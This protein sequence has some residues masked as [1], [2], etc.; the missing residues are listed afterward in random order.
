MSTATMSSQRALAVGESTSNGKLLPPVPRISLKKRTTA[1]VS[2]KSAVCL[3]SLCPTAAT[4]SPP[5]A[6]RRS[7]TPEIFI[8]I[9]L[10]AKRPAP[11]RMPD[12]TTPPTRRKPMTDVLR[13]PFIDRHHTIAPRKTIARENDENDGGALNGNAN[14]NANSNANFI[15]YS[16]TKKQRRQTVAPE[17]LC[18]STSS[19]SPSSPPRSRTTPNNP[20]CVLQSLK[21][22]DNNT[23]PSDRSPPLAVLEDSER[24]CASN[25]TTPNV[26]A[27]SISLFTPPPFIPDRNR[28]NSVTTRDYPDP[29]S[30][31]RRRLSESF[32]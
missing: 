15:Y 9:L 7:I 16:P 21:M 3:H 22:L 8:P 11:S 28:Y 25:R 10:S 24:H 2:T 4:A 30:V 20:R 17:A 27:R 23:E 12:M 31:I 32:F 29:V 14:S 6:P 18:S 1:T 26:P 19:L 5:I 13:G